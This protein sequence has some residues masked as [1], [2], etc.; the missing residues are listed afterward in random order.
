VLTKSLFL[1]LI[2]VLCMMFAPGR[3]RANDQISTL[4]SVQSLEIED[5]SARPIIHGLFGRFGSGLSSWCPSRVSCPLGSH[6]ALVTCCQGF[7]RTFPQVCQNN[8]GCNG[9]YCGDYQNA[10]CCGGPCIQD[11]PPACA[12]CERTGFCLN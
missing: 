5:A 6:A 10:S 8:P 4:A 3:P 1:I 9:S 11:S 7:T 12:G 2:V